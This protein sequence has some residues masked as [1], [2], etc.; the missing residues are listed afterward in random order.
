MVSDIV[1]YFYCPRKVYYLKVLGVPFKTRRKMEVGKEEDALEEDRVGDRKTI[2]GIERS[3][4]KEIIHNIY[5]EDPGLGLAGQV[6]TLLHLNGGE[7]VPVDSK[8]TE[9]AVV[10]RQY[11][12]QLAAYSLLVDRAFGCRVGHGI[13][14]FIKQKAAVCIEIP[15]FEKKALIKDI[16]SIRKILVGESIPR[17][18]AESKCGYCEVAKFCV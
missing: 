15:E 2:Y 10:H 12:K 7:Y 9:E 16:E 11:R 17:K 4:V 14:Y 1:Q 3:L 5:L 8:Y 18:S 13:V 6:D